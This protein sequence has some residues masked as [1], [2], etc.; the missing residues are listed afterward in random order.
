MGEEAKRREEVMMGV[1]G[2]FRKISW[3]LNL[4]QKALSSPLETD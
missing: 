3:R 1:I 2:L 4:L